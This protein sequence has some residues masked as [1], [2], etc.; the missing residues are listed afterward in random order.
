[1]RVPLRPVTNDG[2]FLS[3]DEGQVRVLI[4]I[5]LRHSFFPFSWENGGMKSKPGTSKK[6]REQVALIRHEVWQRLDAGESLAILSAHRLQNAACM[7]P[8]TH[9][10]AP[11]AR[12]FENAVRTLFQYL[13]Q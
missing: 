5:S 4:V 11:G 3:L 13:D 9:N 8:A 10:H 1:M 2:Y 6:L 12:Y 7:L